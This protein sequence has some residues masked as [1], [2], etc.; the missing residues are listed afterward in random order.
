MNLQQPVRLK[1]ADGSA[2][3]GMFHGYWD[4]T[5]LGRGWVPAISYPLPDGSM[6][7]GF[8]PQG[9]QILDPIMSAEEWQQQQQQQAT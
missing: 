5:P 8:L 9:A 7:T 2:V 3:Q 6:T 4:M 1:L